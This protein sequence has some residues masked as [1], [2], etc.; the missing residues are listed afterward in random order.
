MMPACLRLLRFLNVNRHIR[1]N[2]YRNISVLHILV[3]GDIMNPYKLTASITA[4]ANAIACKLTVD[5]LNLLGV[6]LT[7]LG[8]TVLTIAAQKTF[9]SDSKEQVCEYE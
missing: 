2:Q 4:I 9:C 3:R 5:E 6:V 7:Q 1:I 8:D